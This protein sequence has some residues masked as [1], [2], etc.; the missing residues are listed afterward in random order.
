MQNG[1]LTVGSRAKAFEIGFSLLN[2]S[3]MMPELL[4]GHGAK[5]VITLHYIAIALIQQS[6]I[7]IGLH[8][9]AG[10][11]FVQTVHKTHQ[12]GEDFSAVTVAVD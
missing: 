3:T 6:D 12:L 5:I 7:L 9:F 1:S 10:D 8:T 2:I 4:N 11:V